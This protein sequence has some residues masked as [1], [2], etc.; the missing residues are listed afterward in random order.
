MSFERGFRSGAD[1]R[2]AAERRANSYYSEIEP[3][4]VRNQ[5]RCGEVEASA[6]GKDK[7]S[8]RAAHGVEAG[9]DRGSLQLSLEIEVLLHELDIFRDGLVELIHL[10]AAEGS[11]LLIVRRNAKRG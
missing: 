8:R 3:N 11:A 2:Q 9:S 10:L 5:L 7:R 1:P 6:A 4:G